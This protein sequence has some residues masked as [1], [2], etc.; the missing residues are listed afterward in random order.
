MALSSEEAEYN[1]AAVAYMGTSYVRMVTNELTGID[2]DE[3]G[4]APVL[5]LHERE[6]AIAVIRN[7]RGKKIH[8]TSNVG[9]ITNDMDKNRF[10]TQ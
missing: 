6:S 9:Y 1:T 3:F 10:N 2:P 4:N 8:V 5:I 7:K